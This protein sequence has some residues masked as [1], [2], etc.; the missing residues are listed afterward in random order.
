MK[1]GFVF[2]LCLLLGISLI[3]CGSSVPEKPETELEFWIA[4]NVDDFDFSSYQEKYGMFG[5]RQYYGSGYV[6]ETD[7][8]GTQKDPEHCVIYTVTSY[9][10]YSSGK[11]HVTGIRIT[12]PSVKVY[13]LSVNSPISAWD[14]ELERQGFK[15]KKSGEAEKGKITFRYGNGSVTILAEVTNRWGIVF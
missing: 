5:G 3:G 11:L 7:D 14:A 15:V 4:E 8:D 1:K 9:P 6:P 12:D 13:G 10:D 2:L